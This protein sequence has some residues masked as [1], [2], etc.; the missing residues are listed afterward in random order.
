MK[1]C[2]LL[3]AVLLLGITSVSAQDVTHGVLRQKS[4]ELL[5][6]ADDNQWLTREAWIERYG[7]KEFRLTFGNDS[8][9]DHAQEL[10]MVR[11]DI[12]QS[13]K[14]IGEGNI[15]WERVI[16]SDVPV[17]QLKLAARKR[18]AS[19]LYESKDKIVGGVI[20]HGFVRD[21]KGRPW[22]IKNAHWKGVVTYEFKEGRYK[23]SLSHVQ[24]KTLRSSS[25]GIYSLGFATEKTYIPLANL[26]YPYSQRANTGRY[27]RLVDFIDYNFSAIFV[28]FEAAMPVEE[29]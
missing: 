26:L 19:V 15:V 3:A 5:Y 6:A 14:L 1:R 25:L 16:E 2:L 27:Y 10:G 13:V 23:V 9:Y 11:T 29:W 8:R 24:Y 21:D 4:G 28:L 22:G 12:L 18:L 20:E 17:E 7:R